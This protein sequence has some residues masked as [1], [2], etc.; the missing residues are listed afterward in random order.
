MP[1]DALV[2]CRKIYNRVLLLSIVQI[3]RNIEKT[4]HYPF[5]AGKNSF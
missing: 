4:I 5:Q 3:V 1:K 2:S